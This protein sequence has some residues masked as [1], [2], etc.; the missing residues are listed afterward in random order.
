M[1]RGVELVRFN[2]LGEGNLQVQ[3]AVE[4]TLAPMIDDHKANVENFPSMDKYFE[5]VGIQSKLLIHLYGDARY[6]LPADVT[7][8]REKEGF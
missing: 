1:A 7:A 3:V 5:W 4:G 6:P 2:D 8:T